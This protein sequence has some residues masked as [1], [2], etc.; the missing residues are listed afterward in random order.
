MQM[1][2]AS[3]WR[4]WRVLAAQSNQLGSQSLQLLRLV[5]DQ[6]DQCVTFCHLGLSLGSWLPN[7][8]SLQFMPTHH[9]NAEAIM[10]HSA[11]LMND[12]QK[13]INCNNPDIC[14]VALVYW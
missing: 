13:H 2:H 1:C 9:S 4:D 3:S 5:V 12:H 8:V 7:N 11:A 14:I 6:L 10:K